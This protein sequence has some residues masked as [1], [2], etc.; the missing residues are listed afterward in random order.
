MTP[1]APLP[2]IYSIPPYARAVTVEWPTGAGLAVLV[3]LGRNARVLATYGFTSL[4][5]PTNIA[6]RDYVQ[7]P[8]GAQWWT[9]YVLPTQPGP[10]PLGPNDYA[11]VTW[12]LGL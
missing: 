7:V 4:V 11:Q 10:P 12:E 6:G 1:Q 2:S 8:E 3:L 5:V 9:L